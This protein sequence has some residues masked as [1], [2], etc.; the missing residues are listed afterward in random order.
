MNHTPEEVMSIAS[1]FLPENAVS[2]PLPFG[3]GLINDTYLF[4]RKGTNEKYVLQHINGTV[5]P[6]PQDVIENMRRVTEFLAGKIQAMGGDPLRETLKLKTTSEGLYYHIDPSGNYWRCYRYVPDSESFDRNEDP[7]IMYESGRAFGRFLCLLND[8]DAS[9]LYETI[10]RFHDTPNRFRQLH[11]AEAENRAGRV[12]SVRDLLDRVY[13]YEDFSHKLLD[14]H[15]KGQLPLRVTHNDTKTNNVLI[16]QNTRKG[17]CV[18]D[19]DTIM[20]GL[21]AF[22]FGDAIRYGASSTAE[23][24]KD[25]SKVFINYDLYNAFARGYLSEASS[26][27]TPAEVLS[28]PDG[29]K[30]MTLECCVRFLADYLNGDVYFK[31]TYIGQNLNKC[32][33]QLKLVDDMTEHYEQMRETVCMAAEEYKNR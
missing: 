1:A 24:E 32:K 2:Q 25:L 26:I 31:T 29:A 16:D 30:M 3:N 6:R 14:A 19:L 4:S 12:D 22:D 10:A 13:A 5:F 8:Y 33:T 21:C 18:I 20:P 23:D 27:L 7:H 15:A 11:T 17:L 9:K 28:L